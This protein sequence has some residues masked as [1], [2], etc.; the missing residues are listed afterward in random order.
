MAEFKGLDVVVT[1][2]TGA[3][4]KAVVSRLLEQGARCHVPCFDKEELKGFELA[5]HGRVRIA[6]EVD[7]SNEEQVAGFFA[8]C[9]PLWASIHCA[10]GFSM[11]P[12]QE[13]SAEGIM[14]DCHKVLPHVIGSMSHE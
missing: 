11:Q 2:G 8:D 4:G 3:L 9:G 13:L 5:S 1:G 14:S 12:I 10:G 6:N 7:L